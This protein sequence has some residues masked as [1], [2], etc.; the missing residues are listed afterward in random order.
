MKRY[1][2]SIFSD[3]DGQ[4]SIYIDNLKRVKKT[5]VDDKVTS[6]E[7]TFLDGKK[8]VYTTESPWTSGNFGKYKYVPDPFPG[9]THV[10]ENCCHMFEDGKFCHN[11]PWCDECGKFFPKDEC[12]KRRTEK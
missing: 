1:W 3:Y 12:F 5:V 2:F 11:H 4:N 6:F 7:I 10:C 8:K 9:I